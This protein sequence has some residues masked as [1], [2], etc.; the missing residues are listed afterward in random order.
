MALIKVWQFNHLHTALKKHETLNLSLNLILGMGRT[1]MESDAYEP[2][3]QYA[4]VGSNTGVCLAEDQK[5]RKAH[6]VV[7]R[8]KNKA[9]NAA[10]IDVTTESLKRAD[11]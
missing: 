3:I 10:C 8:T 6:S 9:N 4:Q 1:T 5:A 2:T 11:P 7:A